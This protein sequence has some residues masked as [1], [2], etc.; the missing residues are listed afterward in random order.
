MASGTHSA[1]PVK[2]SCVDGLADV[3]ATACCLGSTFC[4]VFG[5]NFAAFGAYVV[6]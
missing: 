5:V 3:V 4:T 1:R 6:Y 2:G